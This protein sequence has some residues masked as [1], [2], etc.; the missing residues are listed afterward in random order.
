MVFLILVYVCYEMMLLKVK[1]FY[2]K[3]NF[4]EKNL[5]YFE[6]MNRKIYVDVLNVF[7]YGFLVCLLFEKFFQFCYFFFSVNVVFIS[8]VLFIFFF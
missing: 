1:K 2:L 6:K 4:K 5:L 3:N 8:K 7:I